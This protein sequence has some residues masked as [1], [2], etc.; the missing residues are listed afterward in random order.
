[1]SQF[2]YSF[3]NYLRQK[4]NSRVQRIS[5][6]AGF[7]CPNRDGTIG[8]KGCYFCNEKGFVSID[9]PNV[10]IE[11]QIETAFSLF[12]KRFKTNKFIAYFQNASNTYASVE[13]LHAIY[14]KIRKYKEFVGLSISTRPDC[15]DEEKLDMISSYND[16][17][18]VWI[19]YGLQ[20]IHEGTLEFINRRHT[21][22]QFQEAVEL[23]AKRNI[24]TAAHIILGLPHE[25]KKDMNQTAD[26]LARLGINGIKMHTFHVL[27]NT[28]FH[29]MYRQEKISLPS[30]QEYV[31][32]ACD[33]LERLHPECVI[34]RLVSNARDEFLVAPFW[35][36]RKQKVL[37]EIEAEFNKRNT[38]QGFCLLK[39]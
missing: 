28:E 1:M 27:K 19:E 23:T 13:R 18:D 14:D 36:N 31:E 10:T 12:Q 39:R 34:M 22:R 5:L 35:M 7:N 32:M 38:R 6:N 16:K 4:F 30:E 3:N 2:Y 24:K 29:R 8:S 20:S 15:I 21:F 11:E 26:A 33:F 9:N 17:Y 37:R 25:T